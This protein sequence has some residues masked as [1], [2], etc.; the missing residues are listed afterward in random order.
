MKNTA[1][2]SK[3][4]KRGL[5]VLLLLVAA[6]TCYPRL[7]QALSP[8]NPIDITYAELDRKQTVM[9]RTVV[10]KERKREYSKKSKRKYQPAPKKFDPNQYS[11]D[12]W[13]Q[14][15]LTERQAEVVVSFCKRGVYSNSELEQIYVLPE[16]L[17]KLIKDSTTYPERITAVE[18]ESGNSEKREVSPLLVNLNTASE[19]ELQKLRGIGPYFAKK[20]SE[21]REKLGGFIN[22]DQL[23]EI[24]KFDQEKLDIIA[25]QIM[26]SDA[27]VIRININ[28]ASTEELQKHPYI[29]WNVANSIVKM[30]TK[31]QKYSNF[32]Q[33][34]ESELIDTGLLRKIQPY[35]TM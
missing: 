7:N 17:F 34:L 35:L 25:P 31:I 6:I 11:Q 19:E 9:E 20:I 23:L 28:E 32:G 29:S 2:L 27:D 10:E 21:H 30:R 15:G 8:P 14:L 22:K 5:M 1:K 24:W 18:H 12:Q 33:L 13:Q 16:A 4:S 3:R 26:V